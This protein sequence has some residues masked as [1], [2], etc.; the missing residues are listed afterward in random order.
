M[1]QQLWDTLWGNKMPPHGHCYLW[2]DYLVNLHVISDALITI[3]YFTIP[4]AL[5][6][7]IRKRDDLHFNYIFVMFGVF[8]FA[9]GLTHMVNIYNV[10]YGA[11]WLS[12]TLKAITA[13]AS[14][15]TAAIIWP[16]IPKVL[17]IPSN[18]ELLELNDKLREESALNIKQRTELEELSGK[19]SKVLETRNGELK[20][21]KKIRGELELK[22]I[23]LECSNDALQQFTYV[24]SHDLKEPLRTINSMGQML[25]NI[26]TGKLASKEH[27]MLDFMIDASARMSSLIDALQSYTVVGNK[28]EELEDTDLDDVVATLLQDLAAKIEESGVRID[29][30]PLGR[31]NV[32]KPQ[33]QQL[34]QNIISNAIK[35]SSESESPQV[36]V[37]RMPG[38]EG[39]GLALY[40]RDN[41]IG[42]PEEQLGKIF[43][44]FERLH[45]RDDYEGTGIGLAICKKIVDRHSGR[46]EV[47]SEEGRGAEFRVYLP[48][49]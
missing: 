40:V 13:L 25:K 8:I 6:Y 4:V 19:L 44:V 36:E 31:A 14:V 24:A 23:E 38:S 28:N 43:G 33:F 15:G 9:C 42:I 11:Y 41:G 32:I 7:L 2:N 34:M 27:Q 37:G 20:E 5:V 48:D 30:K 12:G 29:V 16:L 22:N 10:W 18:T 1:L 39:E 46:I 49:N 21:M 26:A 45:K 3:S 35:F 17:A 47:L